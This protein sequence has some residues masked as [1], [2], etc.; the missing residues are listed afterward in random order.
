MSGALH[1]AVT[2]MKEGKFPDLAKDTHIVTYCNAGRQAGQ[3]R[4]LLLNNGFTDV[5]NGI[6]QTTIE[7]ASASQ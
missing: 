3:A 5:T 4:E 7:T 2:D 6:S 1:F